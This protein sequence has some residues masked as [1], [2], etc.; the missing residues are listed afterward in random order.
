MLKSSYKDIYNINI[1]KES[2]DDMEDKLNIIHVR[3]CWNE[4]LDISI[5]QFY[6]FIIIQP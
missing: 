3:Y 6:L 4:E 1:T 5:N 2:L